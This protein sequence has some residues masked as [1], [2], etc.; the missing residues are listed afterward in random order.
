MPP[1][2]W[3]PHWTDV[4][5]G[6]TVLSP[7]WTA[8]IV[9]PAPWCPGG[10]IGIWPSEATAPP[11]LPPFD[12][13][14]VNLLFADAIGGNLMRVIFDVPDGATPF[15]Q[16]WNADDTSGPLMSAPSIEAAILDGEKVQVATFPIAQGIDYNF[17]A[18]AQALGLNAISAVGTAGP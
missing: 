2:W 15:L 13:I 16:F 3:I 10:I 1:D 11:T 5:S 4:F 12:V 18:S 17:V 6:G 14:D 8:C 7:I 9:D